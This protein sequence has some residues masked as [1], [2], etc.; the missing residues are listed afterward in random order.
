MNPYGR[1]LLIS[2]RDAE[3]NQIVQPPFGDEEERLFQFYLEAEGVRAAHFGLP[4]QAP[5]WAAAEETWLNSW[6]RGDC[7]S[8]N[9]L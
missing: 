7:L 5:E 3:A 9:L 1:R 8:R 6:S 4:W 2:E